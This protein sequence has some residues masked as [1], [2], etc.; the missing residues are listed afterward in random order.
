MGMRAVLVGCLPEIQVMLMESV[1]VE[2]AQTLQPQFA[3]LFRGSRPSVGPGSDGKAAD[4]EL[5]SFRADRDA[6]V[7]PAGATRF[8]RRGGSGEKLRRSTV[9]KEIAG[10]LGK[11]SSHS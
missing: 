2:I 11:E 3:G 6:V 9:R 7:G 4:R 1:K 10:L 8:G 5:T